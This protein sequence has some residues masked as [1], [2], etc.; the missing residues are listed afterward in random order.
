[1]FARTLTHSRPNVKTKE[2]IFVRACARKAGLINW[3]AHSCPQKHANKRENFSKE[4]TFQQRKSLKV[5]V[6]K[7][8]EVVGSGVVLACRMKHVWTWRLRKTCLFL[9]PCGEL[10]EGYEMKPHKAEARQ[11][12][13]SLISKPFNPFNWCPKFILNRTEMVQGGHSLRLSTSSS[14]PAV[15]GDV[16]LKVDSLRSTCCCFSFWCARQTWVGLGP[17]AVFFPTSFPLHDTKGL[18]PWLDRLSK[19]N[20][21]LSPKTHKNVQFSFWALLFRGTWHLTRGFK[22]HGNWPPRYRRPKLLGRKLVAL[23]LWSIKTVNVSCHPKHNLQRRAGTH[24]NRALKVAGC[25]WVWISICIC[26]ISNTAK[27]KLQFDI[28]HYEYIVPEIS[29]SL[30]F[31]GL[32]RTQ[33]LWQGFG[34]PRDQFRRKDSIS[35]I[36]AKNC[37][38]RK[39]EKQQTTPARCGNLSQPQCDMSDRQVRRVSLMELDLKMESF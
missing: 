8:S 5:G 34:F 31:S 10:K 12:S 20:L 3:F 29:K 24:R 35:P 39:R 14:K 2:G 19:E 17:N 38:R 26:L 27:P 4:K 11:S 7:T 36:P 28:S 30:H 23:Y 16:K 21:S 22:T 1:M 25:C 37:D 33:T 15:S 32:S 18:W 6:T 13:C 9:Q